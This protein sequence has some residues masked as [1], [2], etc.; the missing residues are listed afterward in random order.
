M[1]IQG[2][3]EFH[4]ISF[5]ALGGERIG[6][7]QWTIGKGDRI[8][9]EASPEGY[10]GIVRV[11]AG[12]WER[13]DGFFAET[14]PVVIQSDLLLEEKRDG[15][16]TMEEV[17]HSNLL[18][19]LIRLEDGRKPLA[20]VMDRL[21]IIPAHQRLPVRFYP[22]EVRDKFSALFFVASSADLLLGQ[23]V[24]LTRDPAIRR[25]LAQ[26]LAVFSGAVVMAV[27]PDHQPVSYLSRAW[28]Q[29]DG[30]FSA[31]DP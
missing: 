3:I 24:F 12:Q 25:V 19:E 14:R 10:E 29:S 30:S 8:W 22:P 27:G 31:G 21:G 28:L 26:R 2:L 23:R 7:I 16:R 9:L 15:N 20:V 1:E 11:L 17:L 13:T 6:P 18:P 4:R 5:V